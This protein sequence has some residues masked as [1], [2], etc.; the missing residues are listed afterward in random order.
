M[1]KNQQ[2]SRKIIGAIGGM[3]PLSSVQFYGDVISYCQKNLGVYSNNDYPHMAITNLPIPDLIKNSD[4]GQVA[5]DML[6]EEMNRLAAYGAEE[7][8]IVCNTIHIYIDEF[9]KFSKVKVLSILEET[10]KKIKS[11]GYKKVGLIATPTTLKSKIYQDNFDIN[12][13]VYVTPTE[14]EI[15]MLG[16]TIPDILGGKQTKKMRGSYQKMIAN[17]QGAGAEALVFGCTELGVLITEK[18]V[19]LPI[20]NSVTALAETVAKHSL[21]KL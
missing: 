2:L 21:G 13:I 12:G 7:I 6:I 8:A 20:I 10:S 17:L 4:S 5:K 16:E 19:E 11:D 18:D 1:K 9:R 15:K 14:S 3:G